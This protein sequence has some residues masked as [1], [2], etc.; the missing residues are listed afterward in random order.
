MHVSESGLCRE[1]TVSQADRTMDWLEEAESVQTHEN[2]RIHNPSN[3]AVPS[4]GA[5]GSPVLPCICPL[6]P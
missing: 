6:C 5:L 1:G 4:L 2:L 3:K